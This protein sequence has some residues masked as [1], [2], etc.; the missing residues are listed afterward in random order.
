MAGRSRYSSRFEA[1]ILRGVRQTG[2]SRSFAVN[3]ALTLCS[4][5]D[6][7]CRTR[8]T[9]LAQSTRSFYSLA[10]DLSTPGHVMFDVRITGMAG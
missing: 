5:A 3:L 8:C 1:R 2:L 10:K 7:G 4:Q 9:S 6:A